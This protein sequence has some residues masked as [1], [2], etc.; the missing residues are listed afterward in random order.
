MK[1]NKSLHMFN[2]QS[3]LANKSVS[4]IFRIT[5]NNDFI[6]VLNE[7]LIILVNINSNDLILQ[8]DR[9]T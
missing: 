1:E 7:L 4:Y 6:I 8:K 3:A 2:S 9:A 5:N